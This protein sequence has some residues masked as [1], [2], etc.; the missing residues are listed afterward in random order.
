[1]SLPSHNPDPDSELLRRLLALKRHEQ[2]PPKYF[3]H[4]SDRVIARIEAEATS[5]NRRWWRFLVPDLDSRP[6]LAGAYGVVIGGLLVIGVWFSQWD[7]PQAPTG[8]EAASQW[9]AFAPAAASLRNPVSVNPVAA[10]VGSG[11]TEPASSITPVMS[12]VAP[13]H[14]FDPNRIRVEQASFGLRQ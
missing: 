1:M 14:L 9:S 2:P 11:Q 8:I 5:R 13:S 6:V 7:D 10:S 12:P 4:F 3:L